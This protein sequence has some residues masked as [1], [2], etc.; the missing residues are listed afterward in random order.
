MVYGNGAYDAGIRSSR[1]NGLT[2]EAILNFGYLGGVASFLVLGLVVRWARRCY[3][4]AQVHHELV[5]KL[6]APALCV[7]VILFHGS[8][9]DN[10]AWYLAKQVLPLALVLWLALRGRSAAMPAIPPLAP[11][12]R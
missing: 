10:V 6:L 1:I 12:R 3:R 7:G 5:P 4:R 11:E 2:G 8:D 9:L